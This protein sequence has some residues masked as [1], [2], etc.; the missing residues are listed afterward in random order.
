MIMKAKSKL[1]PGTWYKD[2]K[3]TY[4]LGGGH[5]GESTKRFIYKDSA[6]PQVSYIVGKKKERSYKSLECLSMC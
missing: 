5:G 2:L 3:I 1:S 6:G 4:V